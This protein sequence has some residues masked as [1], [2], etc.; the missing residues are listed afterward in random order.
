MINA[1]GIVVKNYLY[2]FNL[3]CDKPMLFKFN[4]KF[5]LWEEISIQSS[6][7]RIGKSDWASVY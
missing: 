6:E 2:I 3:V 5:D 1:T 4:I 7:F